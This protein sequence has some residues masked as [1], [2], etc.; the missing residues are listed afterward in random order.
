VKAV[1]R[2]G[3][4]TT[5]HVRRLHFYHSRR[6]ATLY[7]QKL[8]PVLG[9]G[10]PRRRS[11]AARPGSASLRVEIFW[12]RPGQLGRGPNGWFATAAVTATNMRLNVRYRETVRIH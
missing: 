1:Q 5:S 4:Q 3:A 2:Q 8:R 6:L 10:N 9:T 12:R 11:A 7:N